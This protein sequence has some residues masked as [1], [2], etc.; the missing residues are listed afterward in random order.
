[1]PVGLANAA[2]GL[3]CSKNDGR[4]ELSQMRPITEAEEANGSA[5]R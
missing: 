5:V 3:R 1:M 4:I 2:G